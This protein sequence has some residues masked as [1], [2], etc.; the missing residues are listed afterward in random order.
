MLNI[1]VQVEIWIIS[2][3]LINGLAKPRNILCISKGVKN[4]FGESVFNVD[5]FIVMHK[6]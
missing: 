6:V 4:T 2:N 3:D 5:S 1:S